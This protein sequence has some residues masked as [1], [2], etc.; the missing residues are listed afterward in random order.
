V[1]ATTGA[2]RWFLGAGERGNPHTRLDQAWTEG[3]AVRVLERWDVFAQL[4]DGDLLF[5]TDWRGDGDQRLG[6]VEGTELAS[7]LAGLVRRGVDVRGLVWRSR[8]DQARLSEQEAIALAETVN[9]AGGEV[10]LDEPVWAGRLPPPEAGA[11][12]LSRRGWF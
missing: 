1:A 10:L 5:F 11:A 6:G 12:A 7:V 2:E 9:A 3:N 8:P 4:G